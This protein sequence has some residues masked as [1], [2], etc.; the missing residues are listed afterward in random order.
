MKRVEEQLAEV[1]DL[2][3][4]E[5]VVP[6]IPTSPSTST[7]MGQHEPR[8]CTDRSQLVHVGGETAKVKG[9]HFDRYGRTVDTEEYEF[10]EA[11]GATWAKSVYRQE[12]SLSALEEKLDEVKDFRFD[13]YG[14]TV[15]TEESSCVDAGE[16]TW[17]RAS[18]GRKSACG[19]CFAE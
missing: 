14:R 8:S 4:D 7:L 9:L 3:F 10:V 2:H 5:M 17:A 13:K 12:S 1:K 19:T 11:D 16:A 18:A 6:W 15:G